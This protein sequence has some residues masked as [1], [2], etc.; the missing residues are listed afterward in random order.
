MRLRCYPQRGVNTCAVAAVR[1]VLA[2]QFGV[3]ISE[4]VLLAFG[5]NPSWPIRREGTTPTQLRRMVRLASDAFNPGRRWR[6]RWH[7]KGTVEAL[8]RECAAGRYPLV[9]VRVTP[10]DLHMVVVLA[11]KAGQ[12]R[13]FDPAE[14]APRWHTEA[15]FVEWWRDGAE[16]TW[17]A[18]VTC[19]S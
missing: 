3:R 7:R 18:C 15:A 9:R 14:R 17:Y 12:L 6:V 2:S 10:T 4:E 16:C 13:V 8:A 11:V 19:C 1:T 5:T